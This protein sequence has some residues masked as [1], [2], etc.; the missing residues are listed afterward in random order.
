MRKSKVS[1]LLKP[2]TSRIQFEVASFLVY[3]SSNFLVHSL[4]ALSV[5]T[6]CQYLHLSISLPPKIQKELL[7][8]LKSVFKRKTLEPD[9]GD[10]Q[11]PVIEE[12]FAAMSML[13]S[14]LQINN[15]KIVKAIFTIPNLIIQHHL[16]LFKSGE[17]I[18][19]LLLKF[20]YLY[21]DNI[22]HDAMGLVCKLFRFLH[23]EDPSYNPEHDFND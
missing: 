18:Y 10:L 7:I 19:S 2:F 1:F 17:I 9:F 20:L 4:D 22:V 12:A 23:K 15:I 3:F 8:C 16:T 13:I 14:N 11:K 6:I 5:M 21:D